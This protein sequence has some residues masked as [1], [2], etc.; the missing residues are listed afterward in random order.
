[1]KRTIKIALVVLLRAMFTPVQL[2]AKLC[3]MVSDPAVSAREEV[4]RAEGEDEARQ[5]F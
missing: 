4:L 1:M 3:G 2:G 5:S